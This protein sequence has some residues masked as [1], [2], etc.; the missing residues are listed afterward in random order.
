MS[1]EMCLPTGLIAFAADGMSY[2]REPSWEEWQQVQTY[3]LHM[4]KYGLR[5]VADG[6]RMGRKLFGDEAV[7]K[8]EEEVQLEFPALHAAV[9][10]ELLEVRNPELSDAVHLAIAKEART[11]EERKAWVEVAAAEGLSPREVKWSV[12]AT[13][14]GHAPVV[15]REGAPTR[16]A[17]VLTI[18]GIMAEFD[19]W[20]KN[21]DLEEMDGETLLRLAE[22]LEPAS[23]LH[24]AARMAWVRRMEK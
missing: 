20:R 12:A 13:A 23:K 9:Q 24:H 22:M 19:L 5:I 3:A 7:G 21:I 6:R 4:Q 16:R 10:L 11:P 17:G 2:L 1:R 8:F 18:E 14:A 15:V